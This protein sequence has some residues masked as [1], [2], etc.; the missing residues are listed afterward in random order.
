MSSPRIIYTAR[1]DATP[2]SELRV[3]ANVYA[4]LIKVHASKY[5]AT[6]K[7]VLLGTPDQSNPQHQGRLDESLHQDSM[8]RDGEH[9]RGAEELPRVDH[10]AL[11]PAP[12][13]RE[14]DESAP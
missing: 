8:D 3:L 13:R 6:K 7:G 11:P 12:R 10:L 1:P 4:Y 9:P 5:Q 14:A 2:E